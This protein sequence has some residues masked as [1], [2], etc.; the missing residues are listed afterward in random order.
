MTAL[1]LDTSRNLILNHI[2][3]LF[4]LLIDHFQNIAI[5]LHTAPQEII[6]KLTSA[7]L[8]SSFLASAGLDK[9]GWSG[10][11]NSSVKPKGSSCHHYALP[12]LEKPQHRGFTAATASLPPCS[13]LSITPR[14]CKHSNAPPDS[15][16]AT[17]GAPPKAPC[18]RH[19][20]GFVIANQLF[21]SDFMRLEGFGRVFF[22][23]IE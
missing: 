8:K 13:T 19:A 10:W 4:N 15:T 7:G 16:Q 17:L 5:L 22:L 3:H 9:V 21:N 11:K 14:D 6:S 20:I 1:N 12:H 23:L 18:Q 2:F